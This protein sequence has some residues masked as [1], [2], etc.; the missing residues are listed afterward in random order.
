MAERDAAVYYETQKFRQV[1]LLLLVGA[2]AVMTWYGFIKQVLLGIPFGTKPMSDFAL[3]IHWA[4]VG[5]GLPLLF[6]S[7]K[8]ISIVKEDGIFIRFVPFH[9]SC[10][11]IPLDELQDFKPRTYDPIGE[12]G[13][14]GIRGSKSNRAYNVS[15][16]LGVQLILKEGQKILIGSQNPE[17]FVRSIERVV[18]TDKQIIG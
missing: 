18:E 10:R 11:K 17:E 2:I 4:L 14:W 3:T 16:N 5:I 12:Y 15:G 7:I 9:F 13:G 8:L 6:Y 1:W